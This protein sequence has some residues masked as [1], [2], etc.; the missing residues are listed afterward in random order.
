MCP[1]SEVTF[2]DS[3]SKLCVRECPDNPTASSGQPDT[4]YADESNRLCVLTCNA[5]HSSPLF[6][7]NN[8]RTCVPKCLDHNSYAE[9]QT[10]HRICVAR[11]L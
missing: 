4:Y 6:G 10:T 2:G 8:T 3:L 9:T 5:S 7:N 11:C 1:A